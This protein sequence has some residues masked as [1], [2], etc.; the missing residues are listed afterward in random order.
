MKPTKEYNLGWGESVAIRQAFLETVKNMPIV[1]TK[2]SLEDMGYPKH[3]GDPELV[4]LTKKILKR[5]IGRDYRYILITNGATGGV[6][7]SLRAF[8]MMGYESCEV[9]GPPYFRFYPDMIVAAGLEQNHHSNRGKDKTVYLVDSPSNPLGNF[10]DLRKNL[11]NSPIIWDT[12]YFNKVYCP[13]NYPQPD[14]DVIVGSYSKLT[15][16]NGLRVGWIAT[17][18]ALLYERFRTLVTAEYCGISVASAK[19][20]METAGKFTDKDWESFEKRANFLLNCNR[21]EWSKLERYFGDQPVIP[22]GMFYYAPVDKHC[23]K[24]LERSGVIWSHGSS[25]GTSDDFGIFNLG[26][27]PKLIKRAVRDILRN[28]KLK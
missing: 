17:N 19:I 6:T 27:D 25:L 13:G 5:Q 4:E 15:G 22:V 26:Q 21:E 23:K 1:F 28:D 20:I 2:K 3:E 11:Q 8:K 24:L 14:H 7:I 18:D 16:L 10:S 9:E 12:V